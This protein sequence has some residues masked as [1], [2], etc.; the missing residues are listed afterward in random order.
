MANDA[1]ISGL[2]VGKGAGAVATNTVVGASA[3]GA[4]TTGYGN[5]AVG[6]S[7]LSSNTSG[8][9][10]TAVGPTNAVDV[11]SALSS[12]TTGSQN[13]ALGTGAL[14]A[15]TTGANSTAVGY[16]ALAS[17]TVSS[18]H[19]ALGYQAGSVIVLGSGGTF[20]GYKADASNSS[21]N[22]EMV[23]STRAAGTTGKG[24]STGFIDPNGGG[25]YNGGN[26]TTWTTT[27][28][29][30]IKKNIVDNND[31]LNKLTGIRVRNF[32]YR[33]P[34]EITELAENTAIKKEGIQLGVIAQEI[35]QILPEC[36]NTESTGVMSVNSDN[37]IWYAINAIKELKTEVDSL[38][39]QLKGN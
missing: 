33:L 12:N 7:A 36:V 18:N 37:L 28:D 16:Q 39:Q 26:T 32:E 21:N 2:T 38:K 25:V 14:N 4:N 22:Y 23:I 11:G 13:I 10:N 31:G 27:S 1:L 34:E 19:T 15:N 35:Q 6:R 20:I 5:I 24:S 17:L 29:R 8:N 9:N 3:L 30:R